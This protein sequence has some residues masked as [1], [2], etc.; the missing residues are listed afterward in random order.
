MSTPTPAPIQPAPKCRVCSGRTIRWGWDRAFQRWRCK[1]C[2]ATWAD[3]PAKPLGRMRIDPERA[4]LCLS[5]LTEGSSIRSTERVTGTHRD[6]VTRLLIRVGAKAGAQ[7]DKLVHRVEAKDIQADEIWGFIG[8][9]EKTKVKKKIAD[10]KVGDAYSFV[11]IERAS[12][13]VLAHHLGRRTSEDAHR[14]MLKLDCATSGRFQLT[15]DGFEAYPAAVE[16]RFGSEVDFG[17]LIKSYG[18]D[19]S[20]ERRYSPPSIIGAEK[21]S[22]S[23]NP[24]EARICTSHVERQN[25]TMRMQLR[26]LTRLT[27]GFSKKWE[28]LRAALA[29][30]FWA[31]N[32]TWMHSTIRMT[33]AMRAGI[34]RR[35]LTL[36]DLVAA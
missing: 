16:S 30:H 27:N 32:F 24:D 33:P 25:L 17:Q 19:M 4:K 22:I 11:A 3:I 34:A 15:T 26:R 13:L 5:L 9:K 8:M 28:N 21:R 12:K 2:G 10:D 36:A 6:T 14:F 20:D 18:N 29:L 31:Y 1:S 35:P 23:G 7:L